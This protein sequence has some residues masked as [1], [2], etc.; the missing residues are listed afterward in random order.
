[1]SMLIKVTGLSQSDVRI[2]TA[3]SIND[4][5]AFFR[6]FIDDNIKY[7]ERGVMVY[8]GTEINMEWI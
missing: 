4:G 6:R 3:Y 8:N 1:M 7:D 5:W 2:E